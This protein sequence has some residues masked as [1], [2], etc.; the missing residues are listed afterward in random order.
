M[1]EKKPL[2]QY[3]GSIKELQAGDSLPSNLPLTTK[4]DLIAFSTAATRL[5]VGTDGYV[6]TADS[7]EASGIKWAESSGGG[8]Q[9]GLFLKGLFD[10]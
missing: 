6:L 10:G 5:P 8:S 3:D 1:A 2:C 7:A 9:S 4:G